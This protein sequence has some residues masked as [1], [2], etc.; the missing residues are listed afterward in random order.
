M[1]IKFGNPN[2]DVIAFS[3]DGDTYS[4]G[5]E[6]FIHACQTNPNITL[7]VNDNQSFSLT[8]GQAT[9]TSQSSFKNR[10]EPLGNSRPLNPIRLA[11]AAGASF[12]ARCNAMDIVGTQNIIVAAIKHEGFAFVEVIQDCLVF[13]AESN[14]RDGRMYR[15][16]PKK[17]PQ[18][19]ILAEEY[20]YEIGS[21][22]IPIGIFYQEKRGTLESRW[23]QL[24]KKR[25]K[26]SWKGMR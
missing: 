20:D 14:H 12:V 25:Q 1:G 7:I 8:T 5:M 4:E 10:T 16:T 23:P 26:R 2:L 24:V 9:P 18:A 22:K 17:L 6:H 3:G 13:N 21:G 11:L 15:I 19:R